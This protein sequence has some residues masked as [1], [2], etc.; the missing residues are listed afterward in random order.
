MERPWLKHYERGVSAELCYPWVPLHRLL[1][2]AAEEH[3]KRTAIIFFG[4]RMKYRELDRAANQFAHT[5]MDLGVEPGDRVAIHLPNCPQFVIT[6]YGAL[7]AGAIVVACNPLYVERELAHQLRDSGS[8][9]I[10]TLSKFYPQVQ[11]IRAETP[12]RNVIVTNI[13]DYFPRTTKLLFTLARERQEGHRVTIKAGD[14]AF[15]DL[16]EGRPDGRPGISVWPDATALLQYTGGTTGVPKGAMLSHR[17]LVANLVQGQAWNT[18][19][20]MGKE[21]ILCVLPFFHLYGQAIGMNSAVHMASAMILLPR[22]DVDEVLQTISKHKP[23]LFPGVPTIYVMINDHADVKKYNLKSIRACLSG[24]APLPAEVQRRFERLTG[25]ARLVE[26]YGLTESGP[27]THANPMR[28]RR[29]PGSIGVPIPD[30]E[31]RIVDLETGERDMPVGE[32]GELIIRGPQIMQGYWHMPEETALALRDGWLYTGDIAQ[33]DEDG[34]FYI[35]DRKKDMI[36]SGGVNI[37][38]RELEEVLYDHPAVREAAVIGVP[39]PHWGESPKAFVALKDSAGVTPDAIIDFCRDRLAAYKVPKFV[40][41]RDELPKTPI[42]KVLRRALREEAG[43]S[44]IAVEQA[45]VVA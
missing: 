18:G 44:E 40:E 42:G 37:Y 41:F 2:R 9:T 4:R 26:G 29:I 30:T 8:E 13:K 10:V 6:Y 31:A 16:L 12:L 1:E 43:E 17:N 28:G 20:R 11:H 14:H 21:R 25:G 5:L 36:I 27:L 39:D 45:T 32:A 22:F 24:A 19:A 7:K 23:T 35:V 15:L 34:Y 33:M 3:P 38:P